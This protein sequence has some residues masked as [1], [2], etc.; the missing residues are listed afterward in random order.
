MKK[1]QQLSSMVPDLESRARVLVVDDDRNL[2]KMLRAELQNA[3]YSVDVASD[4]EE[5]FAMAKQHRY[6]IALVDLRMP[7]MG[8]LE[9]LRYLRSFTPNTA[10]V[11]LTGFGSVRESVEA[12]KLGAVDFMEKPIEP[13]KLLALLEEII[14][15]FRPETE[16]TV[17]DL[18]HLAELA[19][20]RSAWN[21]ARTYAKSALVRAPT[22]PEPAYVLGK[23]CEAEGDVS[24][25]SLY[26][27]MALEIDHAFRPAID[28]LNR[29]GRLPNDFVRP[30]T[31]SRGPK[32]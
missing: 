7:K 13:M 24:L 28:A 17:D 22:R 5:A 3:G 31:F 15:R 16:K 32:R 23:I 10:V 9:L 2:R 20:S 12:I 18:V 25:A 26:Y 6:A 30:P 4:G 8:G 19:I 21:E 29:L 14:L 1:L 27:Y 11:I